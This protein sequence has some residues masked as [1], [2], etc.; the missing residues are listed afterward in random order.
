MSW[1]NRRSKDQQIIRAL[2]KKI[3]LL[4]GSHVSDQTEQFNPEDYKGQHFG[5]L[6]PFTVEEKGELRRAKSPEEFE[7]ITGKLMF[8][9]EVKREAEAAREAA[10]AA[11]KAKTHW[12]KVM[13]YDSPIP[14]EGQADKLDEFM[15]MM[16]RSHKENEFRMVPIHTFQ[17]GVI[18]VKLKD[19]RTINFTAEFMKERD[20]AHEDRF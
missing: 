15:N 8:L 5:W 18:F 3:E 19:I 11:E 7:R 17:D 9:R 16:Y 14:I 20:A 10:I 2:L 13:T 6:S 4:E 12:A 1:F